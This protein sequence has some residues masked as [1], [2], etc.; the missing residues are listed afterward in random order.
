[1]S[2]YAARIVFCFWFRRRS[3][4][5]RSKQTESIGGK[6]ETNGNRD[7]HV[8]TITKGKHPYR[9]TPNGPRRWKWYRWASSFPWATKDAGRHRRCG[10]RRQYG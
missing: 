7:S 6:A 5:R 10:H 2:T 9:H 3:I 8:S 1:M 4:S